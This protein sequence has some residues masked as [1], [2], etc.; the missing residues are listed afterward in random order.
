[1]SNPE[2]NI[3]NIGILKHQIMLR[4]RQRIS[5]AISDFLE[6]AD[7]FY[8]GE[9]PEGDQI[10]VSRKEAFDYAVNHLVHEATM[11]QEHNRYID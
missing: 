7:Y 8:P 5:N 1:M 2:N 10:E 4:F 6:E 9:Y 11:M 3:V